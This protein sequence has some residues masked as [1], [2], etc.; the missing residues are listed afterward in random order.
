MIERG[1][2]LFLSFVFFLVEWYLLLLNKTR[3]KTDD[4]DDDY[5]V[6]GRRRQSIYSPPLY[7]SLPSLSPH[8]KKIISSEMKMIKKI[9]IHSW[10]E[11]WMMVVENK[12]QAQYAKKKKIATVIIIIYIN[13]LQV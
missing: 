7:S 4:N 5:V 9:F 11:K 6:Y 2:Y 10:G 1:R 13:R 8:L 12:T 3:K